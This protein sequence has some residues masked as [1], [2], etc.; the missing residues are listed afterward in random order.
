LAVAIGLWGWHEVAFLSGALTGTRRLPA[1]GAGGAIRFREAFA[2]IW[3]HEVAL[4][5]TLALLWWLSRG[6]LHPTVARVFTVLWVMRVS[7]K[8]NLFL[9]VRVTNAQFLP[10]PV[11][12]LGTYFR[13]ARFNPLMPLSLACAT[14]LAARSFATAGAA[15]VG[16]Y[17]R[18][19][20]ALLGCLL[21]LAALEHVFMVVPLQDAKLWSVFLPRKHGAES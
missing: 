10:T 20:A 7:A 8:L 12:Y 13:S 5:A 1:S 16:S 9:G 18:L 15:S 6:R 3:I 11:R 17:A 2:S 14:A 21:C 4:A 19:E